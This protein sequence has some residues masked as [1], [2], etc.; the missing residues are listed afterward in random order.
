MERCPSGVYPRQGAENLAAAEEGTDE[1]TG[2]DT[3]DTHDL[4]GGV[5]GLMA[6]EYDRL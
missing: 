4:G 2:D 3:E 6:S 1:Q 5:P